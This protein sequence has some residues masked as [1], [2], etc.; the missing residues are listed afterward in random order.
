MT[1]TKLP[2]D[3]ELATPIGGKDVDPELQKKLKDQKMRHK[4][5]RFQALIIPR[6]KEAKFRINQIKNCGNRSNY[7]YTE[8]E[9][10]AVIKFLENE[11]DEL[12]N[13]FLDPS[14]EFNAEPI[15]FDTTEYD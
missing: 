8:N 12:A 11:V 6:L 9:A 1:T 14:K 10:A 15:Q 13:V 4:R 5:H 3:T 7:V 2:T